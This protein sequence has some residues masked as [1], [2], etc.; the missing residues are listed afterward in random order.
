MNESVR[1]SRPKLVTMIALVVLYVAVTNLLRAIESIT[2]WNYLSNLVS[3]SPA[4]LT[5]S[6]MFWGISGLLLAL[7]LWL[8]KAWARISSLIFYLAYSFYYWADRLL[9]P[10]SII[11]NTSWLFFLS[12]QVILLAFVIWVMSRQ[13]TKVF[14][15]VLNG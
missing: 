10:G 6:G 3:F 2:L 14:F 15:G 12:L 1:P 13:R 4:Y 5:F 8:G 9:L 11:K 7:G